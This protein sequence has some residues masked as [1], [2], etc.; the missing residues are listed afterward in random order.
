MKGIS[1][2]MRIIIM[3]MV[4]GLL[5]LGCENLSDSIESPNVG[6]L[7]SIPAG[8]F[9]MGSP[10]TESN[11][12]DDEMRHSV[13]LSAF[14]MG[15]YEVTQE[16]YLAVMGNNPSDYDDNPATG[17]IQG[18][19]PVEQVSWYDAIVFCNKLSMMEKLEPAY[20]IS[21]ETD[22]EAWGA[23]PTSDDAAWDAVSCDWNADGY[24]LPTEA[25]WEYVCRAGTTT[26]YNT[27]DTISDNTGWYKT[28]SNSRT[29]EVG[30]KSANAY[31][32][33]D[34]HG[35][36][37]EWCWDWYG[38]SHG[39]ESQIDPK[40]ASSGFSRVERGGSWG[41][42]AE[43]LRSADRSFYY[44]SGRSSNLGFRLLR[45]KNKEQSK[46]S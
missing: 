41:S 4:I 13:T 46:P 6:T 32:L 3:V 37:W 36:V 30:K 31:G 17:E 7:L 45:P 5:M 20:S 22:P 8:T 35:N 27:G 21:G 29:H 40:G 9:T 44:P 23:V 18:K 33:Y 24:R 2:E 14:Y 28:N 11:R 43:R 19:R 10:G 12:Y 34:M 16:Q 39:S 42:D 38:R 15:K 25:E 1:K 26:T